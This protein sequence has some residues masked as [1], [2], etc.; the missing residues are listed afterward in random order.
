[1]NLL[2]AALLYGEKL[3]EVGQRGGF[4][5][6][7]SFEEAGDLLTNLLIRIVILNLEVGF[8]DVHDGVIGYVSAVGEAP[9][10]Q[11]GDILVGDSLA[12]LIQ[13]P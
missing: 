8:Q 3:Q 5:H 4:I 7:D 10:F 12:E 11:E 9:A 13:K 1:M 2:D 6:L